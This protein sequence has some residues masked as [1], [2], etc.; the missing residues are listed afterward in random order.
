MLRV[1]QRRPD[2]RTSLLMARAVPAETVGPVRIAVGHLTGRPSASAPR[3]TA[4][5]SCALA[6]AVGVLR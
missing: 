4:D 5:D 1:E 2:G 6:L 3:P